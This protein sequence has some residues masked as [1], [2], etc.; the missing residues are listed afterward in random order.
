[1]NEEAVA[2]LE[3]S[4]KTLL[5][6]SPGDAFQAVADKLV[7]AGVDCW[8]PE[9]R[10]QHDLFVVQLVAV[11]GIRGSDRGLAVTVTAE[12]AVEAV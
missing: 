7:K 12:Q 1:V 4:L 10:V 6:E 3:A 9:M 5:E 2:Q 11:A 8:G